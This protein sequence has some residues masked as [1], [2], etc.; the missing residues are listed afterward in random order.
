[1]SPMTTLMTTPSLKNQDYLNHMQKK[2]N[3]LPCENAKKGQ[4]YGI[5][6]LFPMLVDRLT[7]KSGVS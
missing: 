2:I 4:K 1:M 3:W 5:T 7:G 6:K